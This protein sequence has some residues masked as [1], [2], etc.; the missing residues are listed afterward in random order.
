[1]RISISWQVGVVSLISAIRQANDSAHYSSGSEQLQAEL[2]ASKVFGWPSF[3]GYLTTLSSSL[4]FPHTHTHARAYTHV[5]NHT[6]W[7]PHGEFLL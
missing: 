2:P 7:G 3:I 6:P 4:S 1:M 5:I